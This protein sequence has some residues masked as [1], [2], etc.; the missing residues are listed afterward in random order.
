MQNL[1]IL[2]LPG[3]EFLNVFGLVVILVL[4]GAYLCI[5][6][7]DR[8]DRRAPPPVPQDPDAMEVAFLQGGVN[9][10]IRTLIYDLAQRGFVALAAEDHVIPTEKQP[11]PG[12]LNAMETRLLEAVRSKPKAHTLFEDRSLRRRLL[13]ELAPVRARLAAEELI[14]PES[15]KIWRRRAQIGGTLI[16]V[17]LALAKIY[18]E[19]VRGPANVAYLVFLAGASLAALF[20]L[21]Y[22]MT[23]THASRRGH[24]Y[25]EAMRL[26]YGGRLKE[27]IAHIGSP[28]P[29]ARAFHGAALFLIGL[30]GFAPLKGTTEAMFVEAFSRGS[31]SQGA[32]CGTS[33]GGSC[34]DGGASDCGAGD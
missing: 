31:G 8:T 21:A 28:G 30:F 34:G 10:V 27:A 17:G 13:V 2:D 15:V 23:R 1:P 22:V 6:F 32:D 26:A 12:E 29:E 33:C 24:A 4:A 9:Q 18:V 19:W 25:L 7:A 11:Q 20:A 14:K 3:P 16:I 5:R